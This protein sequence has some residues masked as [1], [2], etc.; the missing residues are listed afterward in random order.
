MKLLERLLTE[1]LSTSSFKVS[2]LT[3][4]Y[5]AGNIRTLHQHSNLPRAIHIEVTVPG[6]LKQSIV[7]EM[8]SMLHSYVNPDTQSFG[9][10]LVYVMGGI[11]DPSLESF[12]ENIIC[13]SAILG[14]EYVVR[15]L[16]EWSDGKPVLYQQNAV[17]FGAQVEQSLELPEEGLRVDTL[18]NSPDE[19]SKDFPIN[20]E[21]SGA[22]SRLGPGSVLGRPVLSVTCSVWPI[23]YMPTDESDRKFHWEWAHGRLP[24]FSFDRFCEALS[25]TCNGSIQP[26]HEW[27]HAPDLKLFVSGG[28]G[29]TFRT[30]VLDSGSRTSLTQSRLEDARNLFLIRNTLSEQSQ[31]VLNVSIHR[32]IKSKNER[33]IHDQLI[34]LR[35]AL[36]ALYSRGSGSE[37]SFR[38]ATR[39]AWHLGGDK[40]RRLRN[41]EALRGVY[42]MASKVIHAGDLR[43]PSVERQR[44][45]L[46]EGQNA[47]REG[48]LKVL[49][50]GEPNWDDLVLGS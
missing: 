5:S 29:G 8:G 30:N 1:A 48:I 35:I 22:G 50:E 18:P 47:C 23:F 16:S 11:I 32:W 13:A 7:D 24:D 36:E 19:L 37:I 46:E 12:A 49:K 10:G 44:T 4:Q 21:V 43:R 28:E 38:M 34:E 33:S 3:G 9:N 31:K 25:L 26:N 39:G 27:T 42:G 2:G 17:L 14:T 40:G 15:L 41:F 45:V 6:P 20:L